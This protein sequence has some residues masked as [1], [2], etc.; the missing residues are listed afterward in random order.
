MNYRSYKTYQQP[1]I[2]RYLVALFYFAIIYSQKHIFGIQYQ[3]SSTVLPIFKKK[4]ILHCTICS[5]ELK[6]KYKPPDDWN[7]GGFLCADCHIEKT[8]EFVLKKQEEKTRID[9]TPEKCARCEKPLLLE[10]DKNKAKWQWNMEPGSSLCKNC[11]D[12]KELEYHKKINF[13]ALCNKKIG[14]IRYNP[15]PA[16]HIEGQLCR[17]CWD[18]QN[19]ISR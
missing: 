6:H 18:N 7:I 9:Q 15:K 10:I 13:C 8:K 12:K 3:F 1:D 5:K 4:E 2:S 17:E 16:W 14:F 19:K 11:Y